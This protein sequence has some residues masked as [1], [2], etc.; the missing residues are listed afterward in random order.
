MA[1]TEELRTKVIPQLAE[2]LNSCDPHTL[3]SHQLIREVRPSGCLHVIVVVDVCRSTVAAL[4][5]DI[6]G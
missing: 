6:S 3:E 4:T 2:F 5:C 1:A